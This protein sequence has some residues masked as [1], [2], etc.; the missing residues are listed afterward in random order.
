MFFIWLLFSGSYF[1]RALSHRP[2]YREDVLQNGK[3]KI[4]DL[5]FKY[6]LFKYN[7]HNFFIIVKAITTEQTTPTMKKPTIFDENDRKESKTEKE[8][9]MN[10]KTIL[11]IVCGV[12]LGCAVA[13]IVGA[14]LLSAYSLSSFIV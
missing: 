2:I 6:N 4:Y 13:I 10:L 8:S 14:L 9:S 3:Y 12:L 11:A 7:L 5:L 1:L